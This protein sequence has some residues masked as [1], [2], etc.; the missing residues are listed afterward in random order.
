MYNCVKAMTKPL[1]HVRENFTQEVWNYI[2]HKK[3]QPEI[4]YR[5][6]F[7]ACEHLT[8]RGQSTSTLGEGFAGVSG[9]FAIRFS[10]GGMSRA[11]GEGTP[12]LRH[13]ESGHMASSDEFP[14]RERESARRNERNEL[15]EKMRKRERA[16]ERETK[17]SKNDEELTR[18][19]RA[20]PC[21]RSEREGDRRAKLPRG[22][23]R[24][25]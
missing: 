25:V 8:A 18:D 19:K 11:R 5:C 1:S 2:V 20:W 10:C 7:R 4:V 22:G 9:G 16:R 14:S 17:R 6:L 24:G 12:W 23:N 15:Y 13:D 3:K 21:K